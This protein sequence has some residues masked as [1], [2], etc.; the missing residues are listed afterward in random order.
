M[1]AG[2]GCIV[3]GRAVCREKLHLESPRGHVFCGERNAYNR[4]VCSGLLQIRN[5][6]M[7]VL[8]GRL[9]V[10]F[11]YGGCAYCSAGFRR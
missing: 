3:N 2:E 7:S 6:I 11:T 9:D 10:R 5:V 1:L 4:F 8:R